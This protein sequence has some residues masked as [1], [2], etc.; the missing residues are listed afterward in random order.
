MTTKSPQAPRT[1]PLDP[2]TDAVT[3]RAALLDRHDQQFRLARGVRY[4]YVLPAWMFFLVVLVTGF[5][6]LA[7]NPPQRTPTEYAFGLVAE[8]VMATGICG[9]VIWLNEKYSVRKLKQSGERIEA[10]MTNA[11][12]D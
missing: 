10:I 8:F 6:R 11:E 9:I 4:W 5:I 3:Y 12:A 1:P 7:T 2:S